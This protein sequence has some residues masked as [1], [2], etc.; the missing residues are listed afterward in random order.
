MYCPEGTV[1]VESNF[2]KGPSLKSLLL[3]CIQKYRSFKSSSLP[4]VISLFILLV[5]RQEKCGGVFGCG[6]F[7]VVLRSAALY[8]VCLTEGN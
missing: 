5:I 7:L 3:C 2:A 1:D 4:S 6:C 8:S